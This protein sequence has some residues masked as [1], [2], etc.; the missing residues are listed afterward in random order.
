MLIE[1]RKGM[2]LHSGTFNAAIIPERVVL[3]P[4]AGHIIGII[5][6]EDITDCAIFPRSSTPGQRIPH[7]FTAEPGEYRDGLEFSECPARDE[8]RWDLQKNIRARRSLPVI[9]PPEASIF[10]VLAGMLR[11]QDQIDSPARDDVDR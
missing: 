11:Y 2:A 7:S 6:D 1:L 5:P 4:Q 3:M 8:K 9:D 10:P